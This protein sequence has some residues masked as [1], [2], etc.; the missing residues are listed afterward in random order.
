M[1]HSIWQL[2]DWPHLRWNAHRLLAPLAEC[3]EAHGA[4]RARLE[5][6]GL[7]NSPSSEALEED[8]VQT[9]AIESET[10]D[11]E[12]IR[13]FLLLTGKDTKIIMQP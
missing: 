4:L 8:A 13:S 12:Q 11:R 9:A 5:I 1:P 10:L 7:M 3:H 6:A 2:P